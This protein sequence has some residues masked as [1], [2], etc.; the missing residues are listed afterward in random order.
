MMQGW[1]KSSR[2]KMSIP[3]GLHPG[4]ISI[5]RGFILRVL[6]LPKERPIYFLYWEGF[7]QKVFVAIF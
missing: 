6:I 4:A 1:H 7:Q 2:W 3:Q 5:A